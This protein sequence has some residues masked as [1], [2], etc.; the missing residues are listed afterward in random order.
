MQVAFLGT[1]RIYLTSPKSI[2]IFLENKIK[3]S[4]TEWMDEWTGGQMEKC[5]VHLS[6]C[7]MAYLFQRTPAKCN[8]LSSRFW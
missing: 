7:F 1:W 4:G 5:K 2:A 6:I 8:F 3:K